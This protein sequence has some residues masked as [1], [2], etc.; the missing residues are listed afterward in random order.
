GACAGRPDGCRRAGGEDVLRPRRSCRRKPAVGI[1]F[2]YSCL[3]VPGPARNEH[4]ID[5]LL[6]LQL[7]DRYAGQFSVAG[8]LSFAR[9]YEIQIGLPDQAHTMSA[10]GIVN[11]GKSFV[12][13]NQPRY[14]RV[15][16][17]AVETGNS[18]KQWHGEAESPLPAGGWAGKLAPLTVL[19]AF[20][21]ESV[22]AS[23]VER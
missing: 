11:A 4:C 22:P 16:A 7:A 13:Q 3:A 2:P 20:D 21:A 14:Q 15:A 1:G 8:P 18:G 5:A 19:P 12:E 23:I 10:C 6:P 17:L 9:N